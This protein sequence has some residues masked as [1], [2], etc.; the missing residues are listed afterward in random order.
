MPL[1]RHAAAMP[2]TARS[3]PP[4]QELREPPSQELRHKESKAKSSDEF[5]A[6]GIAEGILS[7]KEL[8]QILG[9]LA[10]KFD[11]DGALRRRALPS[12]IGTHELPH[13][14]QAS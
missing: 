11:N 8:E 3:P 12:W 1:P 5:V 7:G 4:N 10:D 13:A 6:E 14:S 9:D 2:S